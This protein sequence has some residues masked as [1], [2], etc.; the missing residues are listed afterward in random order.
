[1][2]DWEIALETF[3]KNWRNKP[4]VIGIL[5]CGSFVTG[6]PTQFS[7]IDVHIVMQSQI[8]WRE[9][10]NKVITGFV[11][12]YFANPLKKL[13][14]YLDDDVKIRRRVTAHMLATG[15]ILLDKTGE[16]KK[17]QKE[18]KKY[19]T[20]QFKSI[21]K[22]EIESAKY[23]LWDMCENLKEVSNKNQDDFAFVYFTFLHILFQT[24][25]EFIKF[26]SISPHKIMRFLVDDSDKEKYCVVDFSDKQ[27][28]KMFVGALTLKKKTQMCSAYVELT[29]YVLNKMGGFAINGW[30]LRLSAN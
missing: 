6:K 25:A 13:T 21:S 9:R 12:E 23:R 28:V 26:E 2:D 17:L 30:R 10:G 22:T 5:A 27:F 1:M 7:D 24:Y 20:K 16:L 11:I 4:E 19:L 15:K 3:L 8:D 14:Q 29:D 18:A